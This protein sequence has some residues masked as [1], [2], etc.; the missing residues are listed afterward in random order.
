[1]VARGLYTARYTSIVV[2]IQYKN[3]HNIFTKKAAAGIIPAA[4]LFFL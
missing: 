3:T 2:T 1:M 4:A